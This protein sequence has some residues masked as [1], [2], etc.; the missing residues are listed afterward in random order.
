MKHA[1]SDLLQGTLDLLIPMQA[2][3]A[4]WRKM[5]TT[6]WPTRSGAH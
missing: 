3:R 6:L 4:D 2:L 1:K 5:A